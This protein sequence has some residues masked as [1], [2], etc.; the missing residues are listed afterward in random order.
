VVVGEGLKIDGCA[1]GRDDH[2]PE[3]VVLASV[4]GVQVVQVLPTEPDECLAALAAASTRGP[5]S[6]ARCTGWK[7]TR[8]ALPV[9]AGGT[10]KG[11]G[12]AVVVMPRASPP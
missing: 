4:V 6:N 5:E 7:P 8:S 2:R 12:D 1:G 11:S 9:L 3:D 10:A